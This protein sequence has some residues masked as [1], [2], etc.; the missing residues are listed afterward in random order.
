[1][2]CNHGNKPSCNHGHNPSCNHGNIPS[3]NHGNSHSILYNQ[4]ISLL[5]MLINISSNVIMLILV[6]SYILFFTRTFQHDLRHYVYLSFK[7][8]FA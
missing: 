2:Q 1:M 4:I 8:K 6:T 3:C 5:S 7:G